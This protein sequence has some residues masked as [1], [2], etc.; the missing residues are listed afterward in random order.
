MGGSIELLDLRELSGEPVADILV[1]SSSLK[2]IEIKGDVVPRAIDEFPVISVAAATAEGRT[3]IRDAHELRVKETDR[4]AATAA[5]L[6]RAGVTV[7]E[8]GDGMVIDGVERL[9]GCSARSCGDHRIAMS[10]LVAGLAAS[11]EISVDDTACIA[12]SFP[13]F[14]SLLEKVPRR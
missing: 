14:L 10:M 5:N 13:T 4:I 9:T 1:R 6:R 2:G 12:T 7:E 11:E 3:T 8:T